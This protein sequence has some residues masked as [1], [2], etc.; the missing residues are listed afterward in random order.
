[1]NVHD[2]R[3]DATGAVIDVVGIVAS[4]IIVSFILDD[5]F[6]APSQN[7]TYTVFVHC[8]VVHTAHT[9]HV[10]LNN[11][12]VAYACCVVQF[13]LS[14]ENCINVAA[15]AEPFNATI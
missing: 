4:Y 9:S 12:L 8:V 15:V 11:L 3:D 2:C 10:K 13:V 5:R 7:L 1:L 14:H 6:H